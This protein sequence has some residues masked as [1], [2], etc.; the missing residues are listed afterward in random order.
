MPPRRGI[1][2]HHGWHDW[3]I[4]LR[5]EISTMLSSAHVNSLAAGRRHGGSCCNMCTHAVDMQY[6]PRCKTGMLPAVFPRKAMHLYFGGSKPFIKGQDSQQDQAVML[7]KMILWSPSVCTN[8][9]LGRWGIF[10]FFIELLRKPASLGTSNRNARFPKA[11]F[12]ASSFRSLRKNK[13]HV[14]QVPGT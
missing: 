9:M 5:Q 4:L 8:S 10:E 11:G 3:M 6:M 7:T 1:V 13:M 12:C 2:W 14:W